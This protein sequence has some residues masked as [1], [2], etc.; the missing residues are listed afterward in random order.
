MASVIPDTVETAPIAAGPDD[1]RKAQKASVVLIPWDPDSPEH[2]ERMKQQRIA[3][4]WKLEAVDGWRQLQRDG[5]I[6]LHWVALTPSHPDT[7][8][9]LQRHIEAYPNEAT[10]LQ[11][12]CRLVLSRPRAPDD[13]RLAHFLPIGHISLDA[14]TAD[15]ELRASASDGVYSVMSFYISGALQKGGL[16][17]AALSSCERMAA[18]EYGAKKITLGTISNEECTPDNPRRIAMGTTKISKPT[19]Q[20]WYTG[21]GYKMYLRQPDAWFETDPTGKSWGVVCVLMEKELASSS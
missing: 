19:V 16:G 15:P 18:T 14:W 2:V 20:D 13:A 4:G 6:G 12:S 21:R 3:C 1:A 9:R 17:A 8:S 10:P 5:K 7:A 11:D